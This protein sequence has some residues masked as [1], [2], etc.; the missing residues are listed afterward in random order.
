[1]QSRLE[2]LLSRVEELTGRLRGRMQGLRGRR[3]NLDG[4]RER[5]H[6]R[7]RGVP[8]RGSKLGDVKERLRESDGWLIAA[9]ERVRP[10]HAVPALL[11]AIALI[12][13]GFWLGGMVGGHASAA[14]LT[15]TVKIKGKV[16]TID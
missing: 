10:W 13:G 1:M 14:V 16:I 7:T 15:R 4:V 12:V 9:R 11:S 8:Y 3:P 6:D 5:L 2:D